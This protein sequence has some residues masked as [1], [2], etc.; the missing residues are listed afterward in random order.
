MLRLVRDL[1]DPQPVNLTVVGV[2]DFAVRR[3]HRYGTVLI[4]LDSHRPIDLLPDREATTVSQWLADRPGIAVVCRDRAGAY[5][6]APQRLRRK[7]SRSLIGGTCGTTCANTSRR[8][9]PPT[10][11]A[12]YRRHHRRPAVRFWCRRLLP[13][14][15]S[16]APA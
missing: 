6:E 9:S 16:P 14:P 2:D 12:S 8:A 4:D 13:L 10:G 15:T 1:P 3:G 11:A 7:R 5:A